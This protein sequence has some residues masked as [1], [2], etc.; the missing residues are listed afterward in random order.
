MHE[1]F[2]DFLFDTFQKFYFSQV[3]HDYQMPSPD[4][5]QKAKVY[6]DE[7]ATLPLTNSPAVFG[8]HTNAEIGCVQRT[9]TPRVAREQQVEQWQ[10]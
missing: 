3:G 7:I 8:L 4:L 10:Q 6:Q 1:Y 5:G 9:R 2:G